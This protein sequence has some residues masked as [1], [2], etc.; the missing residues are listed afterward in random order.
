MKRVFQSETVALT[1]GT[2]TPTGH[3]DE[4]DVPHEPEWPT[5]AP[6]ID[7]YH[8]DD[9][10][11]TQVVDEQP[12]ARQWQT[13]GWHY[14]LHKAER[15]GVHIV[16][17]EWVSG[18]LT[19]HETDAFNVLANPADPDGELGTSH[20]SGM[21]ITMYTYDRPE[22]ENVVWENDTGEVVVRQN[23]A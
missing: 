12:M 17:M 13:T 6:V 22:A 21:V 20:G 8:S 18:G 14:Y 9:D 19:T 7:I 15:T 10:G 5:S 11:V 2:Y 4:P 23:P 16:N 3:P 1:L